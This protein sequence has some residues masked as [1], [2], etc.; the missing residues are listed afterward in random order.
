M[1]ANFKYSIKY[2]PGN[3]HENADFLSRIPIQSVKAASRAEDTMI[4]EQKK[5]PVC[6]DIRDYLENGTLSE[7]NRVSRLPTLRPLTLSEDCP[8]FTGQ[9]LLADDASRRQDLPLKP[10]ELLRLDLLGPIQPHSLQGNN[11]ILV[12]THYFTK[13][14]ENIALPD[15]T[16]LTRSQALIDKVIL[17][18]GPSK[19][20]VTDRG[21]NFTSELFSSLCKKLQ[22]KQLKTTAHHPKT[23][24]FTDII[25]KTVKEML[26]KYMDQG[27]PK[28]EEMLGPVAFAYR[29]SV[30]SSISETPYFLNHNRDPTKPIDQFP[31]APSTS[32]ITSSDYKSQIVQRLHKTS[33]IVKDNLALAREQQSAQYHK[34]TR[35]QEFRV[36][37]KVLIDVRTPMSLVRNLFHD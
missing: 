19:A 6:S 35:Q 16:A 5:D 11:R 7:E 8:T 10:F 34:R 17:Y 24:G 31:L 3:V 18:H 25:N 29:D 13:W 30:H 32:I 9:I 2:R 23:N 15:Q 36:G 1:L 14:V 26:R 22:I 21:S 28:W 4:R 12:I 37:D 27:F 20:I 33:F